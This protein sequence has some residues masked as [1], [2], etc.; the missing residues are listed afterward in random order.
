MSRTAP[1]AAQTFPQPHATGTTGA[2]DAGQ[3]RIRP[4][5]FPDSNSTNLAVVELPR[6]A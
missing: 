4:V 6:T 3:G 2:I 1:F 5:S